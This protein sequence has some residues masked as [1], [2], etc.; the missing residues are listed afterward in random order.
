MATEPLALQVIDDFSG[1]YRFLSNFWPDNHDTVEHYYQAAKTDNEVWVARILGA[2]TPKAAKDLGR[3]CPMRPTWDD[4]KY[5]VM[6]TLIRHKFFQNP[7][8]RE[9]LLA[10]GEA[11][12]IEGN[13]WGDTVWGVCKGVGT[14]WLG[15]ILMSTRMALRV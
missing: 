9:Q 8:L 3:K 13:W 6:T 15:E 5:A 10:T 12:L 2:S 14:N 11:Q 1:K 4:E 7:D